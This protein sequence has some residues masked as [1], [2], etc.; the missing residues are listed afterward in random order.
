MFSTGKPLSKSLYVIGVLVIFAAVYLPYIVPVSSAIEDYL[1]V[2]GIPIA[3]VS[4]IF[5]GRF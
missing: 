2:Y 5:G 1:I 4:V 3:V